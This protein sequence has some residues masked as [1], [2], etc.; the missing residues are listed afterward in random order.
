MKLAHIPMYFAAHS[1][2]NPAVDPVPLDH[3]TLRDE[4]AQ[5]R[6]P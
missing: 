3:W 1:T 4:A 5:H 6:P 2:P